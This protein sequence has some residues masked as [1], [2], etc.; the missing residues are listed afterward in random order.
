MLTLVSA[1]CPS[2]WGD[3]VDAGAAPIVIET[4]GAFHLPERQM[5]LECGQVGAVDVERGHLVLAG[6]QFMAGAT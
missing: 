1:S 5:G 4:G 3:Q 6:R 2:A